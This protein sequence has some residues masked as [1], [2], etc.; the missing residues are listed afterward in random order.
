VTHHAVAHPLGQLADAVQVG[1][2]LG[3]Q[4]AHEVQLQRFD[5]I[6]DHQ[7]GRT[8][9]LGFGQVLVDD[10]AHALGARFRRDRHRACSAAGNRLARRG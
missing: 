4:R 8:K 6:A 5:A 1:V 7:I 10:P 9:Y 3:R 2:R